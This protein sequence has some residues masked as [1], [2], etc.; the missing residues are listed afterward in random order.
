MTR[1]RRGTLLHD[2]T[3]WRKRHLV[4]FPPH[5]FDE[6]SE[7]HLPTATNF[8]VVAIGRLLDLLGCERSND[9]VSS[10]IPLN[11]KLPKPYKTLNVNSFRF[12]MSLLAIGCQSQDW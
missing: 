7:L 10:Y 12:I 11:P 8:E 4:A 2:N 6:D 3:W 1:F 5:F 9:F